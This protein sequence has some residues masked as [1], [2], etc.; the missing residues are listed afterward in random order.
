MYSCMYA[1]TEKHGIW[2]T[3]LT[4]SICYKYIRRTR[5]RY[6]NTSTIYNHLIVVDISN[7]I[8]VTTSLVGQLKGL[9]VPVPCLKQRW[10]SE[11]QRGQTYSNTQY[12]THKHEGM[13]NM[14][15]S[16][17]TGCISTLNR[18]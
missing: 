2:T 9:S 14:G 18:T 7:C 15:T 5:V 4:G 3:D 1:Y 16:P 6:E 17:A 8:D 12:T 13:S 11:A 10:V